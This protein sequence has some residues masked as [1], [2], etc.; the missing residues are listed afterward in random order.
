MGKNVHNQAPVEWDDNT[1]PALQ[2]I[3]LDLRT[4]HHDK[5]YGGI[6][7]ARVTI[8]HTYPD[9]GETY[10]ESGY[11]G[12]ST[13]PKPCLLLIHNTRSIGGGKLSTNHITEIRYSNKRDGGVI[14]STRC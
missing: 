2:R 13:G 9:T 8:T 11:I 7:S 1:P 5:M 12:K 14:Y 10:T 6:A 3:L 4:A